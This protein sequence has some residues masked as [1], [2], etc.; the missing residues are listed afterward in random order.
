[1]VRVPPPVEQ[2]TIVV[3]LG[4]AG[5]SA[6]EARPAFLRSRPLM[7]AAKEI[8]RNTL[9]YAQEQ[10][11]R[12]WWHFVSTLSIF[13]GFAAVVCVAGTW[14]I[15]LP[16]SLVLGLVLVRVFIIYHDVQH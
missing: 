5:T 9:P 3:R 6:S 11:H 2:R 4:T 12:S 1:M 15:R 13:C 8:L 10:R 7:R 16:A 14:T